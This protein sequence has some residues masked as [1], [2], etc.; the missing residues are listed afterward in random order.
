MTVP[1]P[2][3]NLTAALHY[4]TKRGFEV[5]PANPRT[6]APMIDGGM[7]QATSDP[8]QIRAWWT[9]F[10]N[11]LV[12][13]RIPA[14]E[15][16]L[17][18]DP[19]HGGHTTWAELERAYASIMSARTHVS[20][21]D[22]GGA[23]HWFKR[24]AGKLSAKKLHAW[25]KAN[26]VGSPVVDK[27]G[28]ETGKWTSGI[29]ILH[30]GHRYSILPPSPHPAT[31]KP[32]RWTN[33][34]QPA[35]MPSFLADLITADPPPPSKPKPPTST[36][37]GDSI[38]DWFSNRASWNDILTPHG[39]SVVNGDGNSDG[40]KWKHPTATAASSAS[41]KHGCLFVYSP[42]TH[43]P[44]TEPEDPQGMTRF[45]AWAIL[46]HAG[47]LSD[48]A[49]SAGEMRDGARAPEVDLA[50]LV[51]EPPR[52]PQK[53]SSATNLPES[54]WDSRESLQRIRQAAHA[55]TRS[56]DAV[57]L[58]VLA[59]VAAQIPPSVVLPPIAGGRASL[60]FLAGI[61]ASSGGGKSTSTD[62]A[63]D[64]V[65][66]DRRDVVADVPPGSGE[67]LTELY[68]EMV[69]EEQADGKTKKV[70]RQTKT[71]ALIYLDEG[72]ALAEMGNRKGA[73]LLPTLRSAWSGSVIGQSNATQET[74]RVLR[75]HSY[76]MA[77]IIGFQL[78][79]AATLIADAAGGTPQRFVFAS[80]I[81][82]SVPEELVD[83]PGEI[84]IH[85]PAIDPAGTE[86]EFAEPIW[87]E[88]RRRA[89][90]STKGDFTP[91]PLD[92]HSDLV[93]MKVAALLAIIDGRYDVTPEDWTLAGQV[94]KVSNAVRAWVIEYN[95]AQERK[96]EDSY[97]KKAANREAVTGETVEL[98]ATIGGAKS[99]ARK[100]HNIGGP[101]TKSDLSRAA[102]SRAKGLSSVELM[103]DYA[104]DQGWIRVVDDH[105]E[106][107]ESRPT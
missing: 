47:N 26:G 103:I 105:F 78:E 23:H 88:V 41:I 25:A 14:D 12:A 10:P 48:A 56:A 16:V 67:G 5:F 64:L 68:F 34:D 32:Y 57:L 71:G 92:S 45:R 94:M 55:R 36:S 73:T 106:A 24:P 91:D 93:K 60:N 69:G 87:A 65:P 81:D 90:L 40:S 96:R 28:N 74:H 89:W 35:E 13:C 95:A 82:P 46:N 84:V 20:G 59:R 18:I 22:D 62:V 85:P 66:I 21:R 77:I 1:Q 4:A 38:A 75:A 100:A 76:R 29:D 80:A 39:W 86:I 17:D 107:G 99:M 104:V 42:N 27:D 83:W 102:S 49:R 8:V 52:P 61:V 54:F 101:V 11:A 6:K 53:P 33:R 63:R 51:A 98:R 37:S 97:A 7:N 58:A 15:V 19:R 72:Q 70:K 30:H 31:G 43:F 3:D 50:S 44:E 9:E 79:Y 2:I